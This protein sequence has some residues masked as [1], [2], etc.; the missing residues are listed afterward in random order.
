MRLFV[1][2]LTQLVN[3]ISNAQQLS[4]PPFGEVDK[5]D[6]EMK[7]CT[8]DK[9]AEAVVLFDVGKVYCNYYN[10]SLGASTDLESHV[11]IKILTQKGL[12]LANVHLSYLH[13][14]HSEII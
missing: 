3:V 7:E 8:F 9:N 12:D 1:L 2:A 13:Y 5:V 14:N 4:V 10:N 6:L 11:R